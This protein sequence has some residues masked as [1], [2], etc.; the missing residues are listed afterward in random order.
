[1]KKQESVLLGPL[2]S[3]F[4]VDFLSGQKRVSPETVASYRDTFCLLLRYLQ[5]KYSVAPSAARVADLDIPVVLAFLDY[6]EQERH[7]SI[8]SRNQR[9]SAIRSFFRLVALSDP[10]SVSQSSRILAI[11]NKRSERLLVKALTRDEMEAIVAAP[12]VNH[13][14]GRRDHAL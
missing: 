12:N 2:L 1:M 6:L 3:K 10:L 13:W 9:L 7:N 4:F 5:D 14:S 8:R 11:P